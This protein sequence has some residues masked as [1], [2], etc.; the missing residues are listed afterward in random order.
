M[1]QR[2]LPALYLPGRRSFERSGLPA[3]LDQH[4]QNHRKLLKANLDMYSLDIAMSL[5]SLV[6]QRARGVQELA[7]NRG[8]R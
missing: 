7:G 1:V 2:V 8:W 5:R 3:V 6:L 4:L